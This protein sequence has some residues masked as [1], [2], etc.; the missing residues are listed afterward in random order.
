MPIV[1]DP[2]KD[3]ANLAKHGVSLA[4][5][6]AFDFATAVITVDARRDYGELRYRAFGRIRGK[7]FMLVFVQVDD[8]TIRVISFR[9]A[10][11]KEMRRHG[12]AQGRL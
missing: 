5:A 12:A 11:E 8:E 2:S 9:R 10:H 1:F 6:V 3:A 4:E 7:G